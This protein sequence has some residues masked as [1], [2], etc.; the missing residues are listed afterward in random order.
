MWEGYSS[1]FG[2]TQSDLH[3]SPVA[4]PPVDAITAGAV[5]KVLVLL[6][7]I[8]RHPACHFLRSRMDE[9]C[10]TDRTTARLTGWGGR[11]GGRYLG[12]LIVK[13]LAFYQQGSYTAPAG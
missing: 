5:L 2:S 11:E 4:S 6:E 12:Q 9:D 3:I 7:H 1:R 8:F 10:V 13:R